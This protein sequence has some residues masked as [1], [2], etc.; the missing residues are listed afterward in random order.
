MRRTGSRLLL[1]VVAVGCAS[2][3]FAQLV[4]SKEGFYSATGKYPAATRTVIGGHAGAQ[5]QALVKAQVD[6]FVAF[7]EKELKEKP[8]SPYSHES[9]A[10]YTMNNAAIVSGMVSTYEYTGGA[11]G[12][13]TYIMRTFAMHNGKPVRV[14]FDDIFKARAS[15]RPAVDQLVIGKLMKNPAATWVYEGQTKNL[16]KSQFEAFVV[17]REGLEFVFAPYEMGPYS[18]GTIT[19]LCKWSELPPIDPRGPLSSLVAK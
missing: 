16:V 3:A 2:A 17:R 10:E 8:R 19:V 4:Q 11:H 18:S 9:F 12:N 5:F 14:T 6:R 1:A 13:T 7:C 15:A